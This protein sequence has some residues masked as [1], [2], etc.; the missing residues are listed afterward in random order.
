MIKHGGIE[1]KIVV[2]NHLNCTTL[3]IIFFD[4]QTLKLEL[5][6]PLTCISDYFEIRSF[7]HVINIINSLM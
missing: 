2:S 3:K 6:L 5:E 1:F 7:K 4:K